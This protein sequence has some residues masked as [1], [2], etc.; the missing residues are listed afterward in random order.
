MRG[1]L[2]LMTQASNAADALSAAQRN[3][4]IFV[5]TTSDN[6]QTQLS[7]NSLS[8]E[9]LTIV[10][11]KGRTI[12]PSS[13]RGNVKG[14][15]NVLPASHP[16][17]KSYDGDFVPKTKLTKNYVSIPENTIPMFA[18]TDPENREQ[19]TVKKYESNE[20]DINTLSGI[21]ECYKTALQSGNLYEFFAK[22]NT[23][24]LVLSN[25]NNFANY[26]ETEAVG[27]GNNYTYANYNVYTNDYCKRQQDLDTLFVENFRSECGEQIDTESEVGKLNN[28]LMGGDND[29]NIVK[30]RIILFNLLIRK[31]E[32]C[33]IRNINK[34]RH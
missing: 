6:Q 17:V 5:M 33:K 30:K 24:G 12:V 15:A 4:N 22:N 14:L 16:A 34:T 29:K 7:F 3:N 11:A 13:Y 1:K 31:N 27:K 23:V 19:K 32:D 26:D 21:E 20:I 10:D 2:D 28:V 9:G 25:N 18:E 8:K